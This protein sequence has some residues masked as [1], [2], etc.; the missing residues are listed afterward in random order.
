MKTRAFLV[1]LA[2]LAV[3]GRTNAETKQ[4]IGLLNGD[5]FL[6]LNWGGASPTPPAAA[7]TVRFPTST[8]FGFTDIT[9]GSSVTV[10]IFSADSPQDDQYSFTGS[11][12]AV[13]TATDRFQ[14]ANADRQSLN[15]HT[16]ASLRLNTP[17]VEV[18]NNAVLALNSAT[19]TTDLLDLRSDGRVDVN[20]GSSVQTLRYEFDNAA[21]E[22]RVNSGGEL[23]VVGDTT[24]FR[25]LTRVNSGGQLNAAEGVDLVYNSAA[26]LELADSYT[27]DNFVHL[28][29]TG[30]GDI[31]AGQY[32][33]VGNA[34]IGSLMV[35]GAG[36]TLTSQSNISDWGAGPTGNATV[37]VSNSGVAT[38]DDLR[39]GTGDATFVGNVASS[40]TLRTTGTF[41][42]GGGSTNRTV[43]LT[44]D[45]GTFE[46]AGLATFDNKASLSLASGTV[47]FNG[48]ATF[49]AGSVPVWAGGA[50]NFGANST[51]LIDGANFIKSSGA[52]VFLTDG[53]TMRIRNGGSF[54]TETNTFLDLGNATLDMN[55]GAFRVGL[56]GGTAVSDWGRNPGTATTAT[57]TNNA[58]ARYESGLRM[59]QNGGTTNATI[60]G[61]ASLVANGLLTTGGSETSSV[62][63]NINSGG[64]LRSFATVSLQRGTTA[65]VSGGGRLEGGS[66]VLDGVES[67]GV[68]QLTITG[69]GS[70]LTVTDSLTIEGRGSSQLTV[71]GGAFVNAV[72]SGTGSFTV[73][74]GMSLVNGD[75]AT[76]VGVAI[77]NSSTGAISATSG[78]ELQADVVS[79][80]YMEL[81][82]STVTRGVTL[83]AG[84]STFA[85]AAQV[86]SL[87]QEAGA[88]LNFRL[89]GPTTFDDLTVVNTATFD[90]NAVFAVS[91]ENGYTPTAGTTF[92]VFGSGSTIT[93]TPTF[94]F[95][96]ASLPSGLAWGVTFDPGLLQVSVVSVPVLAG[97]YNS[98]G[99]VDAADYTRWRD[100][101]GAAAGTLTNDPA[102]GTIGAAQYT[103]WAQN[104]GNDNNQALTNSTSV[105]EPSA[106]V[107]LALAAALHAGHRSRGLARG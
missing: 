89:F 30:G 38:I 61:G 98:D 19:I 50:M 35:D 11:N 28:K 84:S 49:N 6:G 16:V 57:L 59:S 18:L 103:Q 21:G 72:T 60:S 62:T 79:D 102:G 107:L 34:A 54:E 67:G 17:Q 8:S 39:A 92:P 31:T 83:R 80:G 10:A 66:V 1:L 81:F 85:D 36:S 93:G 46:T 33:D 5:W 47:N 52:S 20:S 88:T 95:T 2:V 82:G 87:V 70:N 64:I 9:L 32:I 44:V 90:P 45:G 94:D 101:V 41:R 73:N 23:R 55:G 105:P 26:R 106:A 27:L 13:L 4:W 24:L 63:L 96:A 7:D 99:F 22:V 37:T 69:A 56:S 77:T 104:Y 76:P 86:G 78:S 58:R 53:V 68:A 97:D 100:N 15:V 48:G 65:T 71:T 29:A 91:L 43:S 3:A 75:V 74:G 40:G 14:F 12:G 25:G 42:M 51:L